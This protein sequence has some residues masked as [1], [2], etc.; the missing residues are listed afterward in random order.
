LSA[1]IA[2]IAARHTS[3]DALRQVV[4]E[5]KHYLNGCLEH[6]QRL[7]VAASQDSIGPLHHA[8]QWW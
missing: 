4:E 3:S 5:A 8:H 2:A 7:S 1:A 6:G